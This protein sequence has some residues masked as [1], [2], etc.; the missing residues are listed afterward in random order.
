M[1]AIDVCRC[2]SSALALADCT[3]QRADL[4]GVA[5]TDTDVGQDAGNWSRNLDRHF[6]GLEFN[7]RLV[8]FDG[9]TGILEPL[10]DRRL[11]HRFAKRGNPDFR[12][13]LDLTSALSGQPRR[14]SCNSSLS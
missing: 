8:C 7:H 12:C 14:G 10:A 9:V 5:F 3:E 1:S 2:G 11:C 13:H 4:D 6:V